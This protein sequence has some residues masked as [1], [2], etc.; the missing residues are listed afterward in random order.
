MSNKQK[1][2][3][4]FLLIALVPLKAQKVIWDKVYK[5]NK[6]IIFTVTETNDGCF[7]IGGEIDYQDG[8]G[9]DVYLAKMDKNG[10]KIWEKRFGGDY[11]DK[12]HALSKTK[13]DG[14]ILAGAKTPYTKEDFFGSIPEELDVYLIKTD[15]DGNK[16]WE[17]TFGGKD[18]DIASAVLETKNGNF[19][20]AGYS[21]SYG[22]GY[23]DVYV[24]KTDKNGNKIWEK[25]FGGK[26]KDKA[27]AIIQTKDGNFIIAG[28][29]ESFG[30]GEGDI[31]LM[32]IDGNGKKIWSKTFGGKKDDEAHAILETEDGGLIIAG[33]KGLGDLLLIKTDKNGNKIW[34]KTF[35]GEDGEEAYS[36]IETE[37][38]FITAGYTNSY[39]NKEDFYLIKVDKKG[40]KI[41]EKMIGTK[42]YQEIAYSISRCPD[43][44]F[45]VAGFT[46]I[47]T[48]FYVPHIVRIN[49]ESGER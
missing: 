19:I 46:N 22:A 33:R 24:I 29:T 14:F 48:G 11:D 26:E 44:D 23:I 35:G 47:V 1:F 2:L 10:K 28:V 16:L 7:V 8:H 38:G 34:Q 27:N 36:I 40:N 49:D 31:Y 9:E 32:K 17:K 30:S 21:F 3:F 18:R 5:K 20:I 15:K 6:G 25:T 39:G 13:D 37:D 41:W 42:E 4:A 45:I 43:G 12:C